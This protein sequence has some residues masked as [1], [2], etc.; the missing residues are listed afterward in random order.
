MA[1]QEKPKL[2]KVLLHNDHYTTRDFVVYLLQSVFNKSENDAVAIMLHVH[3]NGVGI[4]G[5]YTYEVAETKVE[6]VLSL[7][8]QND[9]PLMCS[10]EPE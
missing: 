2:F 1:V 4:A 8:R 5:V 7:A 10:M 6:T 3:N 9:F